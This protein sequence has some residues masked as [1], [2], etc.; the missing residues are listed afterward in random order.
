M[1]LENENI[2]SFDKI[3]EEKK[4]KE[5]IF[6]LQWLKNYGNG[7]FTSKDIEDRIRKLFEIKEGYTHAI[8]EN[9]LLYGNVDYIYIL[10]NILNKKRLKM[11]RI[12]KNMNKK[13]AE[14]IIEFLE[15]LC[16][17]SVLAMGE[18]IPTK[19]NNHEIFITDRGVFLFDKKK[20]NLFKYI[21]EPNCYLIEPDRGFLFASGEYGEGYL[22]SLRK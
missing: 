20:L 21:L 11:D 9:C 10:N 1:N 12:L 8:I 13:N 15:T 16:Y 2:I 17:E 3:L 19:N 7:D 18:F 14:S 6:R 4:L 5:S 22:K